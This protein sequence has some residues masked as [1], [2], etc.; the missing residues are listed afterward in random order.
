MTRNLLPVVALVG[1]LVLAVWV[2]REI[3]R[4]STGSVPFYPITTRGIGDEPCEHT[5]GVRIGFINSPK[6]SISRGVTPDLSTW[7]I[8]A[9]LGVSDEQLRAVV[10]SHIGRVAVDFDVWPTR[11]HKSS[12]IRRAGM[13]P[14]V[15]WYPQGCDRIGG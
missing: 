12:V 7:L 10:G 1:A 14:L 11:C 2:G 5:V 4:A 13:T 15:R 9:C 3:G 6:F 8:D